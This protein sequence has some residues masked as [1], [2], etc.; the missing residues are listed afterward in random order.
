M[1]EPPPKVSLDKKKEKEKFGKMFIITFQNVGSNQFES[2]FRLKSW[3]T[4]K[5]G[6]S[7]LQPMN[8]FFFVVIEAMSY[9]TTHLF[10]ATHV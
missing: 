9:K 2:I 8:V 1:Y 6:I 5:N 7:S 3:T 10:D 4:R